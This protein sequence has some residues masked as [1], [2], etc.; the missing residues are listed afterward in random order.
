VHFYS[1]QEVL[2]E[3]IDIVKYLD[4]LDGQPLGGNTVD[5]ALVDRLTQ[6]GEQG[7]GRGEE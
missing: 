7:R 6:V 2:K 3:S 5:R 4:T 1:P